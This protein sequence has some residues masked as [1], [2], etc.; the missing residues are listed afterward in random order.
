[1]STQYNRRRGA[2]ANRPR[3]P[4]QCMHFTPHRND[5]GTLEMLDNGT[6][7]IR[8][9][10]F[11]RFCDEHQLCCQKEGTSADAPVLQRAG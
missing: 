10:P 2:R 7:C 4:R 9:A 5:D 3:K 1:M 11:N 6:R 8:L